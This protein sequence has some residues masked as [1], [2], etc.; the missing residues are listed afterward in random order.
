MTPSWSI[1]TQKET[2]PISS[3]LNRE[4]LY[5]LFFLREK[6]RIPESAGQPHQPPQH[7][8]WITL[9]AHEILLLYQNNP[10]SDLP[11]HCNIPQCRITREDH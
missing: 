10:N 9:P 11:L 4:L 1:N 7:H 8:I 3:H 2:M 6:V 5:G